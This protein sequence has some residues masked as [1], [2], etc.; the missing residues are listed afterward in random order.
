MAKAGELPRLGVLSLGFLRQSWLRA[1]LRAQGWQVVPGWQSCDAVAV[2]GRGSVAARGIAL[3]Q[4]RDLPLLTIEDSFLRSIHAG[5]GPA[6]GLILDLQG[7]HY[8]PNSG[9]AVTDLLNAEPQP[10]ADTRDALA[11]M[12]HYQLSKYNNWPTGADALPDRFVLVVDQVAGDAALMGADAVAF[13]EMLRAARARNPDLPILIRTH[14]SGQG[15]LPRSNLPAG[16]SLMPQ[17][18]NPWHI[19]P[20]V[21]AAH[22]Y[23]SQLGFEAILAGHRPIVHGQPIYAGWGLSQDLAP[24]ATRTA[25]LTRQQLFAGLM[26]DASIWPDPVTGRDG[27]V[28]RAVQ[29]LA[30]TSAAHRRTY[31]TTQLIGVS[32]WKRHRV[33]QMLGASGPKTTVAWGNDRTADARIEDG[34]LRSRGLGAALVPPVS[35]IHDQTGLHFDPAHPS[36]LERFITDSPALP[37]AALS[38]AAKLR[39]RL[40]AGQFDKYNLTAPP[41]TLPQGHRILIAGQVRGDASVRFGGPNITDADIVQAARRAH[42]T[43][44]LIYKPHP[45]VVAGLRDGHV[46]DG[47]VVVIAQGGLA[48]LLDQV[49]ALWTNTSLAGFEALLRGVPVTCLGW[50]FYAGWGLTQDL[51]PV[52]DDLPQ[53]RG[54]RPDL[55]MLTHA[56]LIDYPLY[57]DPRTKSRCAPEDI[58]SWLEQGGHEPAI[59]LAGPGR[60]LS[61]LLRYATRS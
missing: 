21:A 38:R 43:A 10:D 26:R 7:V 30:S 33:A 15:L 11:L 61:R 50:P 53:R 3:A 14:P 47:A 39:A 35:L 24:I 13:S 44:V 6:A 1:A 32:G 59:P 22:V 27:G 54:A 36:D 2:W 57:L 9:S 23:S 18:V 28:L 45:D 31:G 19:W 55:D 60:V 20:R 34:F 58:L 42:P 25:Q 49:D 4:R 51:G 46:V 40:I 52:P 37:A 8:D 29:R 16:V 12:Q 48:P 56:A 5:H 17:G 41:P